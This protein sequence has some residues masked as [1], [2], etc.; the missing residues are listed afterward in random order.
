M[1]Y[2]F[3]KICDLINSPT[4]AGVIPKAIP[5]KYIPKLFFIPILI[6]RYFKNSIHRKPL[7]KNE[8]ITIGIIMKTYSS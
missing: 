3:F 6:F 8:K 1:E 4:L 7:I 2:L 5:A